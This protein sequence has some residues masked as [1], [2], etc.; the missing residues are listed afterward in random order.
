MSECCP[1]LRRFGV[2]ELCGGC[3]VVRPL[4]FTV[5]I[6]SISIRHLLTLHILFCLDFVATR[7]ATDSLRMNRSLRDFV[8]PLL[9]LCGPNFL[10]AAIATGE[11]PVDVMRGT[12]IEG[13]VRHL[14]RLIRLDGT[15]FHCNV[16]C[17]NVSGTDCAF[18]STACHAVM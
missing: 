11:R 12:R 1:T 4:R 16:K 7:S 14:C 17:L 6:D 5:W 10:L 18:S 15:M 2:A 13:A 8:V 3:V 9:L